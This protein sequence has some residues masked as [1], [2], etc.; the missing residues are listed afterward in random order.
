MP[1]YEYQ[2][3]NCGDVFEL[4]QKFS[5]E[6]TTT[7]E[8]CGGKVHRLISKSALQFK[9][10]GWYVTDYAK[11]GSTKPGNGG[12]SKKDGDSSAASGSSEGGS[13]EAASSP[14]KDSS[15]SGSSS[16]DTSKSSSTTS[17]STPAPSSDKK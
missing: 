9:G 11:S 14:A 2:C 13:K 8:K 16:S 12:G 15:G 5:D 7:H 10:S 6:P 1:L 4:I 17:T 3:E